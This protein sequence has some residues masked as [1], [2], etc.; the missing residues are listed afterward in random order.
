MGFHRKH[1]PDIETLKRIYEECQDAQE[2][3]N[4][5]VGKEEAISGSNESLKFLQEISDKVYP[6]T[7]TWDD[8]AKINKDPQKWLDMWERSQELPTL[9]GV[10]STIKD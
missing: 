8:L 3:L 9:G 5:V 6:K 4:T 7:K 1:I 10:R 2:F